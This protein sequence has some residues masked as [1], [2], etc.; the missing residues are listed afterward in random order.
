MKLINKTVDSL[1]NFKPH[2]FILLILMVAYLVSGVSTP[3]ELSSYVNNTFMHLSLVA[4]GIILFLYGSP[5][6]ALLFVG[7]A[8]VFVFRSGKV[9]HEIMKP[10]QKKNDRKM[11][12]LNTHLTNTS[13][14]E[15]L[16]GQ[17]VRNPENIPGPSSF[18][19]VLCDSH[20]ATTV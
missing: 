13:L 16:V 5:L 1:K 4:F 3:Y 19:P 20:N 2:E 14:E 17:I 10:S 9:S 6:L 11:S 12:E 8:S 18:H 7:V 15:E